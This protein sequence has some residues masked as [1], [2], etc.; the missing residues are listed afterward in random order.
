MKKFYNILEGEIT[1]INYSLPCLS[2]NFIPIIEYSTHITR[3]VSSRHAL[4]VGLRS[5]YR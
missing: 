5:H 2:F 1:T 4:R 3:Q